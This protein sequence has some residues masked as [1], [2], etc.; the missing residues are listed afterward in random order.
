MCSGS[1]HILLITSALQGTN[2]YFTTSTGR[3]L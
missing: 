3:L 1:G 2:N